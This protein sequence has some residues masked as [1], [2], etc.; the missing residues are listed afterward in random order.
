VFL[1]PPSMSAPCP[2][3]ASP[4]DTP[5]SG[6][7]EHN[8]AHGRLDA[9]ALVHDASWHGVTFVDGGMPRLLWGLATRP[10]HTY[11]AYLAGAPKRYLIPLVF[12]LLAH[13]A[14]IML[15]TAAL[16]RNVAV[17]GRTNRTVAETVVLQAD[18]DR[19]RLALP[20]VVLLTWG[21]CRSRY[22]LAEVAVLWLFCIGFVI[23][24][25]SLGLPLQWLWPARRDTIT[26][27]FGWI[28]GLVMLWYV[29]AFFGV[30]QH[31]AATRCVVIVCGTLV[32]LNYAKRDMRRF[33]GFDV[34]LSL[35]LTLRDTFCL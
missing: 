1:F 31:R 27:V 11:A 21:L 24:C 18:E 15:G 20:F 16:K 32:V 29:V 19:Y 23:V 34:P 5:Y 4:Y 3:Y 25:E 30:R 8:A 13:G 26:Y 22:R 6:Y 2:N 10:G 12:L 35:V 17:M 14:Y 33:Y 9:H 7:Y 28:A